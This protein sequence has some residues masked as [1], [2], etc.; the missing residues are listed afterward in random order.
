MSYGCT[1]GLAPKKARQ[2]ARQC[3]ERPVIRDSLFHSRFCLFHWTTTNDH[4]NQN[5][6]VTI[7]RRM[8]AKK[9]CIP[10]QLAVPCFDHPRYKFMKKSLI[11]TICI[12]A[13]L[14]ASAPTEGFV[15]DFAA[16]QFQRSLRLL[17]ISNR[18][19]ISTK[20]LDSNSNYQYIHGISRRIGNV[21]LAA[22]SNKSQNTAA[23][24]LPPSN[25][26]SRTLPTDRILKARKS[27]TGISNSFYPVS[28]EASDVECVALARR[29]DLSS[30]SN[31]SASLQLRPS[32]L[33]TGGVSSNSIEVEGM[34]KSIVTQR[35][36]RT[37]ED[38]EVAVEFPIYC[39][40]R[41]VIP[42]NNGA[43]D[44]DLSSS[45]DESNGQ[46]S[47]KSSGGNSSKKSYRLPDRNIDEMDVMELQRLLQADINSDDD[48]LM[49]DEA[50]YSSQDGQIDVGELVAQLFW[51]KLD[52]YPKKPGT[53][54][55]QRSITG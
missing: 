1:A 24:E 36:V 18:R 33:N 5:Y 44:L 19:S 25:E 55:I 6:I 11:D 47:R 29:F 12:L 52:P 8:Q 28:I 10:N 46:Q 16:A 51:F 3:D 37:N 21:Q 50:I 26:F 31:L 30:I 41:P 49:E 34:C 45:A 2:A 48:T 22:K 40:V 7:K 9:G 38:F 4:C 32:I 42:T 35:C 17:D 23:T 13:I 54:P 27:T 20:I 53:N 15:V 14:S 43:S 39:I